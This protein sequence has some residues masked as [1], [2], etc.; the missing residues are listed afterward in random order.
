MLADRLNEWWDRRK[1]RE[2]LLVIAVALLTAL[3]T[4]TRWCCSRCGS[5]SP[6]QQRLAGARSELAK[7]QQLVEER[8]RAAATACG[9]ARPICGEAIGRRIGHPARP[10]RAGGSA[11]YGAPVVGDPE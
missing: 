9:R 1:A 5:R 11:G 6:F 2:R 7:L 10:D 3:V 4:G 8:D